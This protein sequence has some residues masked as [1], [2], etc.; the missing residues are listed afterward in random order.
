MPHIY[1]RRDKI[2][3]PVKKISLWDIEVLQHIT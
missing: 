3:K 1:A 2:V